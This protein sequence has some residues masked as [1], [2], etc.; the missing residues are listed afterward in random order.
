MTSFIDANREIG[1][2]NSHL[3]MLLETQYSC[4]SIRDVTDNVNEINT[5]KVDG[6]ANTYIGK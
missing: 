5:D 6:S 4:L 1:R 2:K 3:R